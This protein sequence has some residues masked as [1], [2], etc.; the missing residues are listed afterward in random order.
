MNEVVYFLAQLAPGG[1][2]NG[3]QEV[4]GDTENHAHTYVRTDIRTQYVCIRRTDTVIYIRTY[5]Y[6]C[7]SGESKIESVE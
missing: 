2:Q 6:V 7:V 3:R 4:N 5:T 1:D